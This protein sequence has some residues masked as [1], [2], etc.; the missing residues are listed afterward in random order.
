[1]RQLSKLFLV[2][3]FA[4][5][6]LLLILGEERVGAH[7]SGPDPGNTGAPGE[8]TCA[9]CHSGPAQTGLLKIEGLPATY[10]AD[11]EFTVTVTLTHAGRTRFG[12]QATVIDDSGKAAGTLLLTDADRTQ[13]LN[14]SVSGNNRQYIE[15]T[16]TGT[17]PVSGGTG[18]W[19]FKWRAPAASAGRIT[20]YVAGNAANGNF[21]T[22]G[23]T[24]YTIQ[25]S[26]LAP[27]TVAPLA[28]V[29][30]ASFDPGAVAR[31]S[32]VAAFAP[33]NLL[34]SGI[35]TATTAPLPD[36]LLGTRVRVTDSGGTE[37]GAGLF[38]VSPGQIN[39][40]IPGE[41]ASGIATVKV[42]RNNQTVAQGTVHI[43]SVSPGIFRV[44]PSAPSDILA[45]AQIFRVKADGSS[46]IEDIV[47]FDN[48]SSLS[49]A[50]PIEFG[51]EP[52]T[53]FLVLYGTGLRLRSAQS[54]V[55]ATIGGLNAS[56]TYAS[57]APG[58]IGL[59][60]VNLSLSRQL[61]SRGNVNVAVIVDGKPANMVVINVK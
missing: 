30:A 10:T 5:L 52:E 16:L 48:A 36:E 61:V 27:P 47:R 49:V 9:G 26:S 44:I 46:G 13:L 42:V 60:Q 40:E 28:S 56:V 53:I 1:M 18:S 31:G 55:T 15:Q 51:A 12:F 43:D 24:I 34:A 20:F 57:V 19:T 22:S 54:A 23:D 2:G 37:R 38:F 7:S 45:A 3:V 17:S 59:D 58:F 14:S 39:L 11:Q 21:S 4:S 41:T 50:I 8:S 35:A 32:I 33:G 29:S 25:A 6:F